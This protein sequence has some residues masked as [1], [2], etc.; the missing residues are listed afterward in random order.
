[1]KDKWK[2]INI[3]YYYYYLFNARAWLFDHLTPSL[4]VSTDDVISRVFIE[5]SASEKVTIHSGIAAEW[6]GQVSSFVKPVEKRC[7][8]FHSRQESITSESPTP[9]ENTSMPISGYEPDPPRLQAEAYIY[10]TG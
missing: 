3:Q 4:P 1:M 2:N 10:H 6:A 7:A 9:E 8:A 5:S